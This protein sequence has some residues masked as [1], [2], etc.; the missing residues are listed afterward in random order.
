MPISVAVHVYDMSAIKY[1]ES[2]VTPLSSPPIV[3]DVKVCIIPLAS[4]FIMVTT[5]PM[6]TV[7]VDGV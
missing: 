5:P 7:A 2:N 3:P 4:E 1:S 6:S